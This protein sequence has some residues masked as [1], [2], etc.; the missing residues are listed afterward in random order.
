MPVQ[1]PISARKTQLLAWQGWQLSVPA[2]WNPVKVDGDYD[3][4]S[5]LLGDLHNA[6]LGL[7]WK[8]A[9]RKTNPSNWA[10]RALHDEVGKLATK[11]AAD[12]AMPDAD[13]WAVSR[14]YLDNDPPG[15]DVW[16]GQSR[17]SNRVLQVV[18]HATQRDTKFSDA[19]LP[20]LADTPSEQ[21]TDWTIFDL[22]FRLPPDA[23]VQWYRFNAGDLAVGVRLSK[24]DKAVSIVRQIG[25][26]ALALAR[27][28]L[29]RW[30]TQQQEQTRKLY[31]PIEKADPATLSLDGRT[32]T[33]L[34][35]TLHRKRRLWWAWMVVKEQT[36]LAFHDDRRDRLV[37]GQSPDEAALRELM[38]TV[39][40]AK[41][42]EAA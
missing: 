18:H 31:R 26:A 10:T 15:R 14:L 34:R 12:Y 7:R 22:S 9:H 3:E 11:E 21:S 35:G 40:W 25:P 5:V 4:G 33:G 42:A 37:I 41:P 16:V 13:A 24:T 32:L 2:D 8:R 39:G 19:I 1:S 20:S 17:A 29:E 23:R 30:L 6:R 28:P 36:V 38:Q 27:Q